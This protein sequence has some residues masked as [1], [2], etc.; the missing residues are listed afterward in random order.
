MLGDVRP[1]AEDESGNGN[2]NQ[3]RQQQQLQSGGH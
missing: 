3:W 1:A 2:D